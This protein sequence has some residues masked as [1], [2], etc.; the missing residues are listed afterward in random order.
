M[1]ICPIAIPKNS[2]KLRFPAFRGKIDKEGTMC[3]QKPRRPQEPGRQPHTF[4]LKAVGT[5]KMNHEAT[6]NTK[7]TKK[8]RKK[9]PTHIFSILRDLRDFVVKFF[10]CRLKLKRTG[11]SPRMVEP[12]T[13]QPG[14][15]A[16]RLFFPSLR[17]VPARWSH[18]FP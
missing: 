13:I 3:D 11:V 18:F 6:K 1:G 12:D 16:A 7:N 4:Q 17:S 8:S 2:K 14:A 5:M 10:C 9:P 15:Y